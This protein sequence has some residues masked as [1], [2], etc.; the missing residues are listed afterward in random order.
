MNIRII[1]VILDVFDHYGE[2][3]RYEEERLEEALNDEAP[4]LLDECYWIMCGFKTGIYDA[5]IFD[6]DIYRYGYV[7]YLIDK[8]AYKEKEAVFIVAVFEAV[9][10]SVGYYFEIPDVNGL[11]NDAYQRQDYSQLATIAKIYFLGFGVSQDYEKAFEIYSYLYG[12]GDDC[13][14]YYLGFMYEHGYG[15]EQDIEKAMMYYHSRQDD[16]TDYRLG[17]FYMLGKYFERDVKKAYE[18]LSRSHFEEAYLY[19]GLLLEEQRDFAGAFEAYIE[20]AKLFQVECLY[21]SALCLRL[22]LGVDIDLQKAYQL[23]EYGYFFR[24]GECAYQLAMM[25]IDGIAVSKNQQKALIYLHQAAH[26]R[27]REACLLLGQ[28]YEQGIYVKRNHQKSLSYYQLANEIY[29]ELKKE[30]EDHYESI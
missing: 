26:F 15:V 13:G 28:F 19:K 27:S 23:L 5:M 14:A 17:T 18:H 22:G 4:D 16:F 24:H 1:E 12:H 8:L 10:A 25:S 7:Q 11:L 3:I 21:K 2:H 29:D 6:E 30:S 20:G 9:I